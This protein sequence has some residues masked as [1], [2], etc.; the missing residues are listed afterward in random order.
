MVDDAPFLPHHALCTQVASSLE[1]YAVL[2]TTI[3]QFY[4]KFAAW[5]NGPFYKL[6]PE[7]VEADTNDAFR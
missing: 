1:P 2:W 3:S 4:D 6:Q 7:E 5:M